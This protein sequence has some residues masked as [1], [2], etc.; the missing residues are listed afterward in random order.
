[1]KG[2][3]GIGTAKCSLPLGDADREHSSTPRQVVEGR[4]EQGCVWLL[5]IWNTEV[6]PGQADGGRR[7]SHIGDRRHGAA[8]CRGGS[9]DGVRVSEDPRLW[10]GG[11]RGCASNIELDAMP[12]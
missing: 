8:R 4:L 11:W 1:M 2:C 12:C 6:G 5:V 9:V 3:S 10:E 7:A